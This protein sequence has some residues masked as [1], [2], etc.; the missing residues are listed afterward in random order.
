MGIGIF[1]NQR[2]KE[3]REI[4]YSADIMAKAA[5]IKNID[6]RVAIHSGVRL[7]AKEFAVR[8]I[9]LFLECI[10]QPLHIV[11]VYLCAIFRPKIGM[12]RDIN[13][14]KVTLMMFIR[15]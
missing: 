8:G 6:V 10:H 9:D 13:Q 1:I 12:W 5:G 7:T 2:V 4:K 15:I 11:L 14:S 3:I